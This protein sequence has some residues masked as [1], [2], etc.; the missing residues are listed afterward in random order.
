MAEISVD[1]NKMRLRDL[2][3]LE[4]AGEGK[5]KPFLEVLERVATVEGYP[6]VGDIP[7]TQ[8]S[9]VVTALSEAIAATSNPG[10]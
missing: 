6:D 5:F 7:V 10:N 8:L 3:A 4:D 9:D 1:L 2:A